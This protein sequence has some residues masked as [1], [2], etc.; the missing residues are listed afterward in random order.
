MVIGFYPGILISTLLDI[1]KK[2]KGIVKYSFFFPL[3]I[4]ILIVYGEISSLFSVQIFNVKYFLISIIVLSL[5][6][7]FIYKDLKYRLKKLFYLRRYELVLL[8]YS[9]SLGFLVSSIL[10]F[11]YLRQT[12]VPMNND[13]LIHQSIVTNIAKSKVITPR[14]TTSLVEKFFKPKTYPY[15][16]H[17]L[18]AFIKQ[19]MPDDYKTVLKFAILVAFFVPLNI[20]SFTFFITN[21]LKQSI[22]SATLSVSYGL[23]PYWPFGWSGYPLLLSVVLLPVTILCILSLF[24]DK[25]IDYALVFLSTLLMTT[26]LVVHIAELVIWI[27]LI[28][29]SFTLGGFIKINRFFLKKT[30]VI[31]IFWVFLSF[32]FLFVLIKENF[33][34]PEIQKQ[35]SHL[36]QSARKYEFS[37]KKAFYYYKFIFLNNNNYLLLSSFIISLLIIVKDRDKKSLGI[38]FFLLI[39]SFIFID[40]FTFRLLEPLYNLFPWSAWERIAYLGIL[41]FPIL[42]SYIYKFINKKYFWLFVMFLMIIEYKS[43]KQ[44]YLRASGT[45]K[46]ITNVNQYDYRAFLW[47]KDNLKNNEQVFNLSKKGKN[48]A[49]LW[50]DNIT[51]RQYLVFPYPW[52]LHKDYNSIITEIDRAFSSLEDSKIKTILEK[53][54]ADYVLASSRNSLLRNG[55]PLV[56]VLENSKCFKMS[57]P[58]DNK[59]VSCYAYVN[60]L[61]KRLYKSPDASRAY[62]YK[63]IPECNVNYVEKSCISLDTYIV[64]VGDE[65]SNSQLG[66]YIYPGETNK[67]SDFSWVRNILIVPAP[68]RISKIKVRLLS[69]TNCPIKLLDQSLNVFSSIQPNNSWKEYVINV[70]DKGLDLYE[71]ILYDYCIQK[72]DSRDASFAVDFISYI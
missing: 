26:L 8:I 56:T 1:G 20:A 32:P 2:F 63:Y 31:L 58:K 5:I 4:A 12:F 37:L 22:I 72:I 40:I 48:E 62:V 46:S 44:I 67:D 45:A 27:P 24:R 55:L 30:L 34:D 7:V 14:T 47:I 36:T 16:S 53:Y 51:S 60:K 54:K 52:H 10:Y 64:N 66:G 13:A 38:L 35:L 71:L 21:N 18:P 65:I 70:K 42:S 69:A 33:L 68:R 25:N 23:F 39:F 6:I 59:Q 3:S 49:S 43:I 11:G 17:L 19:V 57:Y 50:L 15:G 9:I 41:I 28:F 61:D 29:L